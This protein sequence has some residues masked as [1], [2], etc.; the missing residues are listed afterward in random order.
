MLKHQIAALCCLFAFSSAAM[1]QDFFVYPKNDQNTEQQQKDEGEC[2]VW[3][4]NQSGFDP[5]N[6][7]RRLGDINVYL[8]NCDYGFVEVGHFAVLHGVLD[9]QMGWRKSESTT[10]DAAPAEANVALNKAESG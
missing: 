4:K 5:A 3:S 10:V 8:A 6:P 9:I 2:Y 1:A 7:L